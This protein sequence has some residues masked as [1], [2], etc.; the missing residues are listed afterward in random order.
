MIF[1]G[2]QSEHS[3]RMESEESKLQLRMLYRRQYMH[4]NS[5]KIWMLY[6]IID[7]KMDSYMSCT[8]Q[9]P[10]LIKRHKHMAA[11]LSITLDA[12]KCGH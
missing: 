1:N 9:L 2:K 5:L 11:K 4:W 3:A 7:S 6:L 10:Y 12:N 8:K